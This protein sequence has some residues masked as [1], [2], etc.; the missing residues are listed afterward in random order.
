MLVVTL[1]LIATLRKAWDLGAPFTQ[2][3]ASVYDLELSMDS[4]R[5]PRAI[6]L[7]DDVLDGGLVGEVDRLAD[8][9]AD[10]RLRGGHHLEG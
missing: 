5:D 6:D 10:E 8:R 4:P 1:S 3:D 9:A 7:F 2:R